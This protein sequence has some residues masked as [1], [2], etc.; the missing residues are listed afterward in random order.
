MNNKLLVFLRIAYVGITLIAAYY[1]GDI[2]STSILF[3]TLALFIFIYILIN[4][5]EKLTSMHLI[6]FK[7]WVLRM[8]IWS[9]CI[10]WAPAIGLSL[11][12]ICI[13]IL[14]FLL[15]MFTLMESYEFVNFIEEFFI[16]FI[17]DGRFL[18]I[19][20]IIL[21]FILYILIIEGWSGLLGIFQQ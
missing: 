4:I 3:K 6:I 19:L 7:S 18:G 9:I 10:L 5:I 11:V 1:L 2:I 20:G 8:L 13:L 21:I 14:S 15:L 17:S 12:G 16:S